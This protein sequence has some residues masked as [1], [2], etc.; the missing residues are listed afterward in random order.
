MNMEYPS[1]I[2][3]HDTMLFLDILLKT[4]ATYST[5]SHLAYMLTKYL[6]TNVILSSSFDETHMDFFILSQSF[7]T[8]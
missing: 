1:I 6:P 5:L 7:H 2:E 8:S 4:L 3:V